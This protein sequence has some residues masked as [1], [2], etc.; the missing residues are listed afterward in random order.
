M[1]VPHNLYMK[2]PSM[3]KL[4]TTTIPMLTPWGTV[5]DLGS[6]ILEGEGKAF[7]A[8]THGNPESQVSGGFFAVTK[9]TFRMVYP[10]TEHAVVLEGEVTL[11]NETTGEAH[12][13]KPGEGWMIEK[14]TPVLWTVHSPRF[15]KHYMAVV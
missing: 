6:E 1:A 9:S 13:Y 7:G 4:T 12:T 3:L 8:F 14:G 2:G 11:Q 5:A 15:V 10:F